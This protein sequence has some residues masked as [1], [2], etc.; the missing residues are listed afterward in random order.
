MPV[1]ST[2]PGRLPGVKQATPPVP[3]LADSPFVRFLVVGVL[4]TA[5]G[6]ALFALLVWAGLWYPAAA[7]ASK[8]GGIVFNFNTTGRLVF[9][10]RDRT[11]FW[12]F[13]AVYG[14]TYVAS[15]GLM[16]L[17]LVLGVPVLWTGAAIAL[18]MAGVAFLLQ[19]SFVFRSAA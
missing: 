9:G 6:Y 11:L 16:R 1:Q 4:N 18:P 3:G 17:G 12:R 2:S 8:I 13:L 5:F 15:V 7:A 19:K 14:V 10:N